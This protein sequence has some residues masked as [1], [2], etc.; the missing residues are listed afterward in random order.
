M[1]IYGNYLDDY[2]SVK[3]KFASTLSVVVVNGTKVEGTEGS[4]ILCTSPALPAPPASAKTVDLRFRVEVTLNGEQYSNTTG[5][6][7]QNIFVYYAQVVIERLFP[8]GGPVKGDLSS[9]TFDVYGKG[10]FQTPIL[11]GGWDPTIGMQRTTYYTCRFTPLNGRGRIQYS[12]ASY[13]SDSRMLCRKPDDLAEEA[14]VQL[15]IDRIPC[16]VG[17]YAHGVPCCVGDHGPSV[18]HGR[19]GCGR[20]GCH[21]S[22]VL[23]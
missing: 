12:S 23:A 15:A 19:V 20:L 14:E 1:T 3:C 4:Y 21:A 8:W 16:P 2:G 18:H 5:A 11:A 22:W 17:C 9:D 10:F 6:K 13:L 7:A